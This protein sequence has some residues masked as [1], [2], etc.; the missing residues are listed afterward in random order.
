MSTLSATRER[1]A[2]APFEVPAS[3]L[4]LRADRTDISF[5]NITPDLV[6]IDVRVTNEG[7]LP[8]PATE[9]FLESAPLGAFLDWQPLRA[10]A[11]PALMPGQSTVI[12]GT[13]WIPRPAEPLNNP[14]TVT[15][16][17]LQAAVEAPP[18]TETAPEPETATAAPTARARRPRVLRSPPVVAAD[19]LAVLGRGGVYWAGNIDVLMRNKPV[20]RHL[21]R[22][23]RIYPGKTNAAMFFV[24]DRKDGYRFDLTGLASE[25]Q[26]ELLDMTRRPTLYP[27]GAAGVIQ[28]QWLE[29]HGRSVFY[30]LLRPPRGAE[31][32]EVQVHVTRQSDGMEAVVE[33]SLDSRAAGAGCY[34]V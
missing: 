1:T 19:P 2:S 3:L 13:A 22:A 32:G 33:F 29:L 9:V 10:L 30:L 21:A 4:G 24:G 34:T 27:Q 14:K 6:R 28:G 15:P 17:Q 31:R 16:A 12:S 7:S 26:A 25:W 8:S 11:V 23:L 18:E 20:E 5:E